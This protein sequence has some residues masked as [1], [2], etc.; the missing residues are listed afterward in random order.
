[1]FLQNFDC[2]RLSILKAANVKDIGVVASEPNKSEWLL[3]MNHTVARGRTYWIP[4]G[5]R[6]PTKRDIPFVI[7]VPVYRSSIRMFSCNSK[8]DK[9]GVT[10][11]FDGVLRFSSWGYRQ[12]CSAS[13]HHKL[14]L[15][16]WLPVVVRPWSLVRS[17]CITTVTWSG[18]QLITSFTVPGDHCFISSLSQW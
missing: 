10:L 14:N 12:P 3:S 8:S 4:S 16:H 5:I 7:I 17:H 18:S 13:C 11:S 1:M 9:A 6:L 2:L 15:R